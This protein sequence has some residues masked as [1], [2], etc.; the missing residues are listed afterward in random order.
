MNKKGASKRAGREIHS[1][2]ARYIWQ[3]DEGMC[4]YCGNPAS[5][6][7]HIIPTVDGGMSIKSNLVC[8]C[9]RCNMKKA[10][11]L[12]EDPFWFTRAIFWLLQKGEDTSWM[13]SFYKGK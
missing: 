5:E 11:H 1:S 8:V 6:L 2:V 7:D 13:D 10:L 12:E 3:R 9:H 4:I